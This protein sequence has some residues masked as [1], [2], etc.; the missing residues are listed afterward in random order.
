VD[1]TDLRLLAQRRSEAIR[2]YLV[3]HQGI[4][5]TRLYVLDV[6]VDAEKSGDTPS[7]LSLSAV[8]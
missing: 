8:S 5:D 6:S 4:P 7:L 3:G 2:Q 1:E